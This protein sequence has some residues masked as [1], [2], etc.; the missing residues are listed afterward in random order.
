MYLQCETEIKYM[1]LQ[2]EMASTTVQHT[3]KDRDDMYLQCETLLQIELVACYTATEMSCT[4]ARNIATN[5]ADMYYSLLKRWQ[6]A[7]L[8]QTEMA[9]ITA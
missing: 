1:Y 7:T 6:R 9:C 4:T 8:M 3:A 2:T 5:R